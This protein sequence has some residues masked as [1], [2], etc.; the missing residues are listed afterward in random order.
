MNPVQKCLTLLYK[1]QWN[2]VLGAWSF[3][4]IWC[5]VLGI[6]SWPAQAG[7][8]SVNFTARK[9]VPLVPATAGEQ[10]SG[11]AEPASQPGPE[12]DRPVPTEP[13]R[14]QAPQA[15]EGVRPLEPEPVPALEESAPPVLPE[16]P[17]PVPAPVAEPVP[18]VETVLLEQEHGHPP[19][20]G[21]QS[22]EQTFQEPVLLH[23]TQM[24]TQQ[25]WL[26]PQDPPQGIALQF[27][28]QDGDEAG[29]YWEGEEEVFNPAEQEDLWYYGLLPEL[30]QWVTLEILA[31][32]LDLQEAQ[33]SG[34]RF[35]TFGGRALW[36]KTALKEAPP[37]EGEEPESESV[38]RNQVFDRPS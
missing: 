19:G 4:G 15:P 12:P 14:G 1:H 22:H 6:C 36:G 37:L 18:P 38:S 16:V 30:D 3:L 29:V 21:L 5:L 17:P 11:P 31:E 28:H 25:V 20:E 27:L 7:E 33:V 2:L 32:D 9:R 23:A 13:Q 24:I 35:V 10:P 8:P 34:A 26:D